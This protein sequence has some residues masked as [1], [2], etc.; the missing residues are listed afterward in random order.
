MTT[1]KI[2]SKKNT[3]VHVLGDV[4]VKASFNNTI[5][6]ITTKKGDTLCWQSTGV[7]GFKGSRKSTPYAGQ[8]VAEAAAKIAAE[9]FGMKKCVVYLK[10][11][12]PA[13]ES[14]TRAVNKYIA[15]SKIVDKTEIPHGGCR[16]P[17][18]RRV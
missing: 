16:Q 8:M 18:A 2:K 5:V 15:V 12:G 7:Q 6:T 14:A 10:G 1:R 11:P 3:Q 13:R 4:H 17:K 9:K